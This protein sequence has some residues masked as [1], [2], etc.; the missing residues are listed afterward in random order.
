MEQKNRLIESLD[1]TILKATFYLNSLKDYSNSIE[2][3][4]SI[5]RDM[6]DELE[7]EN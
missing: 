4:I 5:A 2:Q 3:L 7:K 1:D 6:K